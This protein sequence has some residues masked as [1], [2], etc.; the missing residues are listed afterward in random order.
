MK[1][2]SFSHV[3]EN[4]PLGRVVAQ[5]ILPRQQEDCR[6]A[7]NSRV[8]LHL[9]SPGYFHTLESM[10]CEEAFDELSLDEDGFL[11]EMRSFGLTM[12]CYLIA[13]G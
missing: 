10:S 6:L 5:G 12:K 8:S 9:G 13:S 4:S 3:C 2:A 1:N 11:V 7:V